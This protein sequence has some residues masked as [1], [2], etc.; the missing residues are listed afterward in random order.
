MD[1]KGKIVIVTGASGGIGLATAKLFSNRG[2]KV[3]LVARSKEKLL[4]ESKSLPN[5]Y[6]IVSDMSKVSDLITMFKK[7]KQ[8]FRRVDILINNAGQGYDTPIEKINPKTLQ[9]IF[10][11]DFVGPI[12][13]MQQ[14]IPL[15]R[16][17]KGGAIVNVSSG[18]AL[19]TLP[20]MGAYSSIKRALA[21]VSLTAGVELKKDNIYVGVIYPY[22]T[23]TDFEKNTIKEKGIK[24]EGGGGLPKPP[25]SPEYVAEKIL[26]GIKNKDPE[27]YPHSWMKPGK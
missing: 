13:A 22:V 4:R 9:K 10:E 25:D 3:V 7:V 20:N 8:K 12:V 17:Q 18:T 14:V 6:P 2:S 11:L 16:K 21:S 26:E 1:F 15:M 5:S 27:I 19:M 23:L 24:W